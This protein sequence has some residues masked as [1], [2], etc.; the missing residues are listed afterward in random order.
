MIGRT[1]GEVV[2]C[3]RPRV[4]A[5]L[6]AFCR[7]VDLA[8]DAFQDACLRALGT[9]PQAG[10]P[11]NPSAWL[12]TVA[13][14]RSLDLLRRA[15]RSPVN[16]SSDDA[17]PEPSTAPEQLDADAS[18]VPDE[19]L[20]LI[21]TCCHP[22]LAPAAQ[23]ALALRHICGLTTLEIAR[24]FLEP[25]PTTAQRLVRAKNKI[26]E[27]GIPYVVPGAEELPA[28]LDGVLTTLY[29]VFNEAYAATGGEVWLRTD[30]AVEAIRL[31][32]LVVE[33]LPDQP[34]AR[35]LLALMRLHHARRDSRMTLD[36]NL[37]LLED[38]DRARWHRAEIFSAIA[39]LKQTL[40]RQQPGPYQ[41]QASIVALHAEALHAGDTD[42][43]Q[44]AA[45]YAALLKHQPTAIVQLNAAVACAFAY[46][47]EHGLAWMERLA[48]S[49]ELA[50]Y[51]LLPAAQAELLRRLGRATEAVAAYD[52][53]LALVRAPNERDHLA[54]RRAELTP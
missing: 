41:L 48:A 22:A 37:I 30:L 51:H 25:E 34:E 54:R 46:G 5:A 36:G 21:F 20:Q 2:R 44:I 27:A 13:K 43:K 1:L 17:M 49:G 11:Q 7:D 23:V 6:V 32:Q 40:A 3:E 19:R 24:A 45:L 53:A 29:L 42:W 33:L 12:Y 50:G 39:G 52:Q 35:G 18:E 10:I 26:R 15:S 47:F 31:N 4:L 8:E 9:W 38:Q 16:I 28:R 14:R